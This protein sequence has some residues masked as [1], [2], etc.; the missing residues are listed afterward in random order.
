MFYREDGGEVTFI[1]T[2]ISFTRI[3]A[4]FGGCITTSGERVISF[5]GRWNDFKRVHTA[6]V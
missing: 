6:M 5:R 1:V 2:T 4:A 3:T